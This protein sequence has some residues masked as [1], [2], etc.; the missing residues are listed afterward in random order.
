MKAKKSILFHLFEKNYF[1]KKI[2]IDI[3]RLI[4]QIIFLSKY[5]LKHIALIKIRLQYT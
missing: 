4:L 2:K 5:Q 1:F 3:L